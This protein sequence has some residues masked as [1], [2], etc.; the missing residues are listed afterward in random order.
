M[1]TKFW[2]SDT[3]GRYHLENLYERIIL[4]W[5]IKRLGVDWIYLAQDRYQRKDM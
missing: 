2:S 1:K 3:K 4:K 5:I